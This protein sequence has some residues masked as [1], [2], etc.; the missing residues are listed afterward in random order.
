M[1]LTTLTL[2]AILLIAQNFAFTF[3]SRARNSASLGRHVTAALM[4]NGVWFLSQLILVNEVMAAIKGERGIALA[5]SYG[6]MYTLF[7]V[8]GSVAAH[9]FS[10]RTER[11]ASAVG[12]NARYK[13]ITTE[14]WNTLTTRVY[15]KSNIC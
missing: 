2:W 10:L 9:Y 5:V 3:V 4:S 7:T 11:G 6:V 15:G 12:A 1:P 8:F 13:Q 14:E